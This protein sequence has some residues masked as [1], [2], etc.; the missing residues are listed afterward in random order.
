MAAM[1]GEK[2]GCQTKGE[3][4]TNKKV[5]MVMT[6]ALLST[7]FAAGVFAQFTVA[8]GIALSSVKADVTGLQKLGMENPDID[9]E[10]G[11]G[12][13]IYADYRLPVSVPV[14]LGFEIGVAGT[15]YTTAAFGQN[16]KDTITAVPLLIR[17]AYHFNM[18][19]E[20]DLYVVG[21]IGYATGSWKGD[22]RNYAKST[23]ASIDD[24]GGFAI[25][26]DVGAAYYFRPRVGAFAELGFTHY[27]LE[28][29]AS[30][31][32]GGQN[33]SITLEVPFSHFLTMGLSVKI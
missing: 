21:K 4:M 14:S 12:G 6:L 10:I 11:F 33:L 1:Y 8:G 28:T 18:K 17:V 19:P 24:I 5:F 31:S 27:G 20:L 9:P 3:K 32:M 23:G 29:E 22:F 30:I 13:N 25:G 16:F 7:V 26:F 2:V 15:K